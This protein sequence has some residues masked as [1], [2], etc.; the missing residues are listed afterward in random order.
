[1][2]YVRT[3]RILKPL[4][5]LD[6]LPLQIFVGFFEIICR[7]WIYIALFELR[8]PI[9]WLI[10]VAAAIKVDF[11]LSLKLATYALQPFTLSAQNI[12]KL[13]NIPST[14]IFSSLL[15][16]RRSVF[17]RLMIQ[18]LAWYDI[19]RWCLSLSSG[20]TTCLFVAILDPLYLLL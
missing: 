19:R 9:R 5:D 12:F 4:L 10:D 15:I 11:S 17:R 18:G 3:S 16:H 20:C 13:T 6:D 2:L 1:M 14:V 8:P 7:C